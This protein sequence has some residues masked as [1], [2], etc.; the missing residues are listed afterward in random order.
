MSP[1][2]KESS[3]ESVVREIR[4]HTRRKYAAEENIRIVLEGLRGG[5]RKFFGNYMDLGFLL[6]IV[7]E[8]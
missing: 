8:H 7:G 2:P 6:V 5:G 3:G 4:R 1:K